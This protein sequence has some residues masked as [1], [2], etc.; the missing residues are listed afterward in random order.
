MSPPRRKDHPLYRQVVD[1]ISAKL[2]EG[3]WLPG[4][5]LPSERALCDLYAVSQITVRRALRELAHAGTLYSR[6]GLG[7]FVSDSMGPSRP[8]GQVAVMLRRLDWLASS[9]LPVLATD[10]SRGGYALRL[11][12]S[13]GAPEGHARLSE[14]VLAQG[15]RAVLVVVDGV[16][17]LLY[18]HYAP[19]LEAI[20][21]PV[22]LLLR[23]IPDLARPAA[24]LDEEQGMELLARHILS[25]GHSRVAYV[26]TDPT[27]IDGWQRYRGFT[28]ALW[29]QGLDLPLDWIFSQSLSQESEI[30]RFRRAFGSS[31]HATALAC[32]SDELAAEALHHLLRLGLNC[33]ED[34]AVV[35]LGDHPF[36]PWLSVPLTTFRF[37]LPALGH[38]AARMALDAIAG[39]PVT[40]SRVSGHLV[41]RN[42]CGA[43]RASS[44]TFSETLPLA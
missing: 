5:K 23:E 44:R 10:L 39:K 32:A 34:V 3:T 2:V 33:P 21:V 38:V 20:S 13:D 41:V 42:S 43:A 12:L 15:D 29:E 19:L 16:E 7:W 26:G 8:V 4:D 35:G 11:A 31:H 30:R 27:R 40:S 37:D 36:S 17:R 28:R 9:L 6:H 1:D 25:L 18:E 14:D 22:I 24:I